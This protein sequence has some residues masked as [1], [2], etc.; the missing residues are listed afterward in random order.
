MFPRKK[1]KTITDFTKR[2]LEF[3][4][5]E[6]EFEKQLL[7]PL[8]LPTINKLRWWFVSRYHGYEL[9]RRRI[10]SNSKVLHG[11]VRQKM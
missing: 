2:E 5:F 9:D 8:Y 10:L 4:D 1:K 11:F 6:A 3:R 7:H